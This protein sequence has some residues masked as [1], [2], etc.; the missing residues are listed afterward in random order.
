MGHAH[1][2]GNATDFC[3]QVQQRKMD[4]PLEERDLKDLMAALYP[5]RAKWR[6]LGVALEASPT[7]LDAIELNSRGSVGLALQE[8]LSQWLR[9]HETRTW[10]DVVEALDRPFVGERRR[11]KRVRDDHCEEY[12]LQSEPIDAEP[13]NDD[14]GESN[15][16]PC[17]RRK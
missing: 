7:D 2:H 15:R 16:P 9:S 14:H 10:P 11:A 8:I 3:G 1:A 12:V 17:D 6:K 13:S 5:L 4:R